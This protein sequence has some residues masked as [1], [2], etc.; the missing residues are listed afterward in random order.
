[1]QK[2]HDPAK[3]G[4]KEQPWARMIFESDIDIDEI[5]PMDFLYGRWKGR[6]V[7]ELGE[8]HPY[9]E[10]EALT[11]GCMHV[12]LH[13]DVYKVWMQ[14]DLPFLNRAMKAYRRLQDTNLTYDL[15]GHLIDDH[16]SIVGLVTEPMLGRTIT[17]HDASLV[18][19]ALRRLNSFGYILDTPWEGR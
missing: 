10:L 11:I 7:G 18:F 9:A 4:I 13:V 17:L 16:D 3:L 15:I 5:G 19:S 1:M 6:E 8:A 12:V 14:R 2:D